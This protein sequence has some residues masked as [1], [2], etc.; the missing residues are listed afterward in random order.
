MLYLHIK[1]SEIA[2]IAS[3]YII[4]LQ[5]RPVILSKDHTSL[6]KAKMCYYGQKFERY[7]NIITAKSK[8]IKNVTD[9]VFTTF[10]YLEVFWPLQYILAFKRLVRPLERITGLFW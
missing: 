4:I 10:L 2:L 8:G 1:S 3:I 6:L 5:K 9:I 7:K